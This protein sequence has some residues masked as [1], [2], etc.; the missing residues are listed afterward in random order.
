MKIF[1]VYRNY[2]TPGVVIV[3]AK[4]EKQAKTLT[5]RKYGY[6]TLEVKEIKLNKSRVIIGVRSEFY[7]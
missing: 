4:N 2:C 5:N 7:N 6:T 3:V 1:E